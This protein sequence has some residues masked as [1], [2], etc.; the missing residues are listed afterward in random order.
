MANALRYSPAGTPPLL[1]ACARGDR[2]EVRV[3][4]CG[5]GVPEADRDRMFVPFQRLGEPGNGTC[6]GVGLALSRGLIEATRGTLEPEETPGGGLTMTMS[7]PAAA[8]RRL[9]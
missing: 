2:V 6:A 4:D 1:T 8:L 9:A 3:I 5:P 7:V